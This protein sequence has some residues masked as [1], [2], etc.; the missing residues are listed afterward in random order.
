[1]SAVVLLTDL[2]PGVKAATIDGKPVVK[3]TAV[4]KPGSYRLSG[5]TALW[6]TVPGVDAL[7]LAELEVEL[8]AL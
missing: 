4:L 5:A 2:A 6:M 7:K 1:V 3:H 8:S